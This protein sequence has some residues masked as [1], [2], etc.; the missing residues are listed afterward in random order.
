MHSRGRSLALAVMVAILTLASLLIAR[1]QRSDI[2]TMFTWAVGRYC[3][4]RLWRFSSN[5]EGR[6]TVF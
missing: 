2:N 5:H 4:A 6:L 1:I 3:I